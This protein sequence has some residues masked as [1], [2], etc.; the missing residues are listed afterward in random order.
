MHKDFL[1]V[2]INKGSGNIALIFELFFA[3]V[4]AEN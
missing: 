3:S 4:I 1:V 2:S